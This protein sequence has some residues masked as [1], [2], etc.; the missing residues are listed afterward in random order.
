LVRAYLPRQDITDGLVTINI[1][2]AS[3]GGIVIDNQ[4]KRIGNARV[5]N[6]IYG[7]IPRGSLLSLDE[8]DRTLLTLSDMPDVAVEGS[9][10]AGEK[11]GET[12]LGVRVS[13]KP[14]IDAVLGLDNFGSASTGQNRGTVTL[15]VNG[16]LGLGEQL[17]VY[18]LYTEGTRYARLSLTAPGA[19]N[20]LR[21][22]VNASY[23]SYRVVSASFAQL[24]VEGSS[25]TGG[26][27]LTYPIVRSRPANLYFT[28]N[29]NYNAFDNR[30]ATG[31]T[32]QYNTS[33]WVGGL[34]GNRI[35]GFAGGGVNVGSLT[36]SGGSVNLDASPS[37][38][39]DAIGPQVNG[40]FT[41][42][43][44]AANR[45]QA[46]S[47]SLS[48]YL[49]VSGQVASKNMDSSEQ[50]YLGGPND[51]R[52]YATGQGNA[53][54]G[55]LTTFEL[56]QSLPWQMQLTGFYDYGHVQTYK[57]T[58]FASAPADNGYVLQGFGAS[59]AWGGQHGIQ[60]K[61]TW[62]QRTGNLPA[63]VVQALDGN[64][65]TS[66]NRYWLSASIPL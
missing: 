66:S 41:K 32:S 63:A 56:R 10:Q 18:G 21:V 1:V 15:N 34:S 6:W 55:M 28:S 16:S 22:G 38:Q 29:F 37:L 54:Q 52:A 2:E 5:E 26:L 8:L 24:G 19:G 9:L 65:G 48:A 62:A 7:R 46:L 12:V 42:L 33:V 50:L 25:H 47:E 13:D 59:L 64:G 57:S 20:G 51:V 36:L 3:L 30:D 27:E 35:D 11:P 4:S 44:Y 49:A 43:R 31:P 60:I 40:H 23:L 58:G 14:L 61:G 53:S 17:G 39:A 45:V